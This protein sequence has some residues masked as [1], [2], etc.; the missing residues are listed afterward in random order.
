MI[1]RIV[2]ENYMAHERTVIEPAEGL[3]VLIGPNNCGK[4]AV[5]S[6][7][8]T[9]CR[10]TDGDFMVR[11]GA[12]SA[13]VTVETSDG[14]VVTWRRQGKS[15]YYDVDGHDLG[16]TGKNK[17]EKLEKVH[18][19]LRLDLVQVNEK[20][21]VD[22]HLALQ[23]QPIFLLSDTGS[24]AAGFFA[25]SSD[26][27][28]LLEMQGK[29]RSKVREAKGRRRTLEEER[30]RVAGQAE[31]LAPLDSLRPRLEAARDEH[32][33]MV[34]AREREAALEV[35]IGR[36]ALAAARV[37]AL[38]R[39][40]AVLRRTQPPPELAPTAPLEELL[41]ELET[42]TQ[43]RRAAEARQKGLEPLALPPILADDRPLAGLCERLGRARRRL[44]G[45]E[46]LATACRP[47]RDPPAIAE[48]VS[49]E[50]HL[51][52]RRRLTDLET[53]RAGDAQALAPLSAP[54]V[55]GDE[56][57][58]AAV[59]LGLQRAAARAEAQEAKQRRMAHLPGPPELAETRPLEDSIRLLAK[60]QAAEKKAAAAKE[61]ANAAVGEAEAAIRQ[62]ATANPTC[63]TCGGPVTPEHLL[64][65]G[66]PAS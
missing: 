3:T 56:S 2:L 45:C 35:L 58:L 55:L 52:A 18:G 61:T 32:G 15:S 63:P 59:I 30:L 53:R 49:L 29:H 13:S 25:S 14:H 54:P 42:W 8:E 23:K 17:K 12:R 9:L 51:A 46:G 34:R 64:R 19:A 21:A 60:A 39:E 65:H 26:A 5:I 31:A 6:A 66:G 33:A 44:T 1:R 16:T 48:T 10:G 4:S 43:R 37:A 36:L 38:E 22:V 20:D 27:S 47:L 50:R 57:R 62:W 28:K 11:H 7:L 40:G 41:A 24:Q